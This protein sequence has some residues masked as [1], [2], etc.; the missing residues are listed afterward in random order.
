MLDLF[1]K[2]KWLGIVF[3]A[4]L[5]VAGILIVVFSIV[6]KD[7]VT[8]ILAI[9]VAVVCF[10]LGALYIVIGITISLNNFFD[11]SFVV[12]AFLVAVGVL[13]LIE[14]SIVSE[15]LVYTVSVALIT[16]GTIY[17]IRAILYIVN[18]IKV[19][20]IVVAFIIAALAITFG[21][22]ALCFKGELLMVLYIIIGVLIAISGVLQIVVTVRRN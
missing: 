5:I 11:S 8:N 6:N 10:L 21:I 17:L 7:S 22:L 2:Y 19:S 13:L 14:K 3:G 18:K 16:F 4:L 9:I 20:Y 15:I 1:R 12:G